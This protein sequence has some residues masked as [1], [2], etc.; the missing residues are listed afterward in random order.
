MIGDYIDFLDKFLAGKYKFIFFSELDNSDSGQVTLRHDIDHN[1]SIA[2]QMAKIEYS[3]NKLKSTYFFL[4]TNN[5]YNLLSY[6]NYKI[7]KKIKEL[8]HKISLHF[9]P[10][11]YDDINSGLLYE[12]IFLRKHSE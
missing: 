9:D 2:F 12:K 4:L 1:C 5:S 6:E 10:T 11:I 3:K 8:G 7:V